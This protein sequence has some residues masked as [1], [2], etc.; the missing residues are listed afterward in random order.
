MGQSSL[1]RT[2]CLASFPTERTP[3]HP[4]AEH[5]HQP[6]THL[7]LLL[8]DLPSLLCLLLVSSFKI[9]SSFPLFIKTPFLS[10]LTTDPQHT[11]IRRQCF[12]IPLTL[13][14]SFSSLPFTT[15][16]LIILLP[17]MPKSLPV[18]YFSYI[19]TPPPISTLVPSR[20]LIPPVLLLTKITLLFLCCYIPFLICVS[21][22]FFSPTFMTHFIPIQ[23]PPPLSILPLP[24]PSI[25]SLDVFF[26]LSFL[27][28]STPL[29]SAATPIGT[30]TT[31]PPAPSNF[32]SY[33][34][35]QDLFLGF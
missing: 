7:S 20:D 31:L 22:L 23:L 25:F 4:G 2:V 9:P 17:S 21:T 1:P 26:I 12:I 18:F 32:L 30:P 8:Q 34:P 13:F 33:P 14:I 24:R 5:P 15:A 16:F 28:P 3:S 19:I 11:S 27:P 6:S 10:L 29:F 35:S